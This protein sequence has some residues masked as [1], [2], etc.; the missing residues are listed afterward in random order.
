MDLLTKEER[1]MYIHIYSPAHK[2][3]IKAK[4][5]VRQQ[6]YNQRPEVKA[7]TKEY[8][9]QHQEELKVKSKERR[10]QQKIKVIS[11]YSEGKNCCA[12]CGENKMEFLTI[13]H[14]NGGGH[15]HQRE[16]G[17][18]QLYQWLIKNHFPEGFNVLCWNCNCSLG[19][20]GYCPH[21]KNHY[22]LSFRSIAP[23]RT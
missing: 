21:T 3:A 1:K 5:R 22:D 18:G 7:R 23:V 15:K 4:E 17:R 10:K 13:N 11:H 19:K 8:R 2:E 9:Q 6:A 16:I 14:I 12:C 20:Y